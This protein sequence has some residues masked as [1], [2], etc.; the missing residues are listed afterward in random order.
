MRRDSMRRGGRLVHRVAARVRRRGAVGGKGEAGISTVEVVVAAPVLFL[1]VVA[2]TGLGLY[3]ENAAEVQG[4]AQDAARMASLQRDPASAYSYAATTAQTDLGS[5]CN[6]SPGGQ[7]E[8]QQ[9]QQST[10]GTVGTGVQAGTVS[11]VEITV[12]CR[13]TEF[14]YSYTITRSSY[15]PVDSYRGGRP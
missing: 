4:A 10:T 14:G 3:A 6:D 5:T 12:V 2:M 9:P 1:F 7:P 11:L 13:V 8:L 15:A